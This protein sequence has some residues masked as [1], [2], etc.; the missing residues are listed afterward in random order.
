[1]ADQLEYIDIEEVEVEELE[2]D[3]LATT[4]FVHRDEGFDAYMR[5]INKYPMLTVEEEYDYIK[6]WQKSRDSRALD[7]VVNSHLRLAARIAGGYLGYG[8]PFEDLLSEGSVGI[9]K[10]VDRFDVSKGFRFSTYATWWIQAA[11][12]EYILR[13]W[14]MV[15]L[16]TTANQKKLFFQLR[17]LK[18]DLR[19]VDDNEL[20]DDYID[21]IS[22]ELK[23]DRNE[24][25]DMNQ[26]MAGQDFSLNAQLVDEEG[27]EWQDTLEDDKDDQET[28]LVN[29][30]LHSK[31]SML[32]VDA[33][34]GLTEREYMIFSRRH[35]SE[36]PP[37]LAIIADEMGMSRE[38]VRQIEA[39]AYDKV[40]RFVTM[41]ATE[42]RMTA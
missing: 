4:E 28:D 35:L 3:E 31:R 7:K 25:L 13:M 41:K 39:A 29:R 23:I 9:L 18:R 10:A 30:D 27:T 26:R 14:S 12:K 2:A 1:M 6:R 17:R 21:Q 16:G 42:Q 37:T 22:D 20:P 36:E 33:L 34:E 11:V 38:R 8:L 32:L 19:A 5:K 24:V 40:Q 15:R